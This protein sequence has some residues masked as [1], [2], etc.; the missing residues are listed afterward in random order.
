MSLRHTRKLRLTM[1]RQRSCRRSITDI[2]PGELDEHILEISGARQRAQLGM[3]LHGLE[4]G[5]RLLAIA[6]RRPARQF[7]ALGVTRRAHSGPL[8]HAFAVD[9]DHVR[10]DLRADEPAWRVFGDHGAM[11]EDADPI[12]EALGLVHEMR[13]EDQG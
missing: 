1:W 7:D 9:L 11:I 8:L 13:G 10:L 5:R 2:P 4:Q 12:A 6:E 3:T